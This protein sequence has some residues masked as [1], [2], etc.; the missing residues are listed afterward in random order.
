MKNFELAGGIVVQSLSLD[1]LLKEIESA[2]K[3]DHSYHICTVNPEIVVRAGQNPAFKAAV[4]ACDLRTIDGIG[5]ILAIMRRYFRKAERLTG[6][7]IMAAVLDLARR[8]GREVIIVGAEALSRERAESR[9]RAEEVK[10]RHG[11]S[12]RVNEAGEAEENLTNMLPKNG[13]VLV[14]LGTPKQELWIRN[15]IV[16]NGPPNLYIGV[17]GAVDY[18]SGVAPNPPAILCALGLEWLYRLIQHPGTRIPRLIN[19]LPKFFWRY[20]VVGR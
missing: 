2:W 8:M 14:A 5:V 18:Y 11:V 17:G 4:M 12:P 9:M 6:V 15:T 7:T 13:V 1:E 10:I 16:N 19:F 3:M 20:I